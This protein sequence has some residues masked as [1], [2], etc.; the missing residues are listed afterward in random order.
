MVCIYYEDTEV[1]DVS[2]E[3]FVSWLTSVATLEGWELGD[4]NIIFCSDEYLLDLN[5]KHLNHDYYTDIIT[6]DY[7]NSGI[8]SGD[9]F[10]SV[11]RVIDNAS[12][13]HVMFHVEQNR[14]VVHGVLHLMGYRD[15]TTEEQIEMTNKEDWALGLIVPRET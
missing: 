1:L 2:P 7:T 11:D 4:I 15:K 13:N 3:F 12:E 6:F 8:I 9:L 14:V 10:I 5:R